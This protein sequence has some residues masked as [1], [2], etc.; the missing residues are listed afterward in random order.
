[1]LYKLGKKKNLVKYWKEIIKITEQILQ[2]LISNEKHSYFIRKDSLIELQS[3]FSHATW[4]DLKIDGKAVTPRDGAPVEINALWYNAICCYEDMCERNNL[5]S[6]Q[7]VKAD[8]SIINIKEKLKASFQ[9]FWIG[10]YLADRLHGDEPVKEFRPNG[11][12]AT[13]LP[14][15]LLTKEQME[16]QFQRSFE[17]LYTFYG[18][19][20][21]APSDIKFRKK[22]Y[23]SQK[24]RDLAYHNGSVWAWLLGAFCGLYIKI[25]E[26]T[27]T[28]GDLIRA[29]SDFIGCF[30][31][32]FMRGHIASIAELWDGDSPHFPKGAPAMALSVAAL[33]NIET[34]IAALEECH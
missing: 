30:R 13:S 34:Y 23:G 5:K 12:L 6:N 27:K 19:R 33:Y 14:W 7:K 8:L 10:D 28:K 24:D 29:L 32:S 17:E 25:Y 21:L 22:Y 9:K 11:L 3:D 4:M 31:N 26:E 18:I 1:M 15:Q 16:K 20:S 2:T